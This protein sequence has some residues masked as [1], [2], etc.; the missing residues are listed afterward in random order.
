M[1][2]QKNYFIP[3]VFYTCSV[4]CSGEMFIPFG[5]RKK[6]QWENPNDGNLLTASELWSHSQSG[7]SGLSQ[8]LYHSEAPDCALEYKEE[9]ESEAE[10]GRQVRVGGD[11]LLIGNKCSMSSI[12]GL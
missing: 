8:P 10:R 6:S 3:S 7:L 4:F 1:G 5:R 11:K 2:Q 12:V 9:G